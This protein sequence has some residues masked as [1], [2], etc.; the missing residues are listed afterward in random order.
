MFICGICFIICVIISPSLKAEE[1]PTAVLPLSQSFDQAPVDLKQFQPPPRHRQE[2]LSVEDI[3]PSDVLSRVMLLADE[4]ELIRR[5]MG[6]PSMDKLRIEVK[7]A[8]ARE[9][10]Y[11]ALTLFRKSNRLC[12][13]LAGLR[14]QEPSIPRVDKI[15]FSDVWQVVNS[16]LQCILIIKKQLGVLEV[17]AER[18]F[19]ESNS[20]EETFVEIIQINRQLNL[21]L[22]QQFL[23]SDQFQ[24]V[25]LAFIYLSNTLS[26]F[27]D[28]AQIATDPAFERGK[29]PKDVYEKL[30][31][32]YTL[33]QH[34]AGFMN[35]NMLEFT[36]TI[37]DIT[38]SDVYD[39]ASLIVSELA[40]LNFKIKGKEQFLKVYYPGRKFPSDVYQRTGRLENQ[41]IEFIKWME[42]HANAIKNEEYGQPVSSKE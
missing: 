22:E 32:S 13:E 19:K 28:V 5:E 33:I 42:A 30:T 8:S 11:Q 26:L 24:Q 14:F 20:P 31:L 23:A 4:V 41:L 29:Q 6:K 15:Q 25:T 17:S 10:F 39:M 37:N 34:I 36:T 12:F 35:A 1:T 2:S 27:P 3:Q 9:V 21:L 18:T 40:Y 38:P 16:A 7:N